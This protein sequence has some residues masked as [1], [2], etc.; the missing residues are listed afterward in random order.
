MESLHTPLQIASCPSYS[1]IHCLIFVHVVNFEA[2]MCRPGTQVVMSTM[3]ALSDNAMMMAK[4]YQGL[5]PS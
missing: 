1:S 4:R 2:F 3:P 5:G